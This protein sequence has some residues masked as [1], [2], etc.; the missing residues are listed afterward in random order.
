MNSMI[1]LLLVMLI[2]I[3]VMIA[4]MFIPYWT[5]RTESFGVSIP[6]EIYH[7]TELKEM[8]KK[9]AA[10]IGILSILVMLIFLICI[11]FIGDNENTI[12]LGLSIMVMLLIGGGFLVYLRFH[13]KMKSLKA[14][15]AWGKEKSSQVVLNTQF[16]NQKLTYSNLWFIL[17]F[18]I[19]LTMMMITLQLYDQIPDRIPMQYNFE[20]E[21]TNWTEKSY[22]SVLVMPIMQVYLTLLFLFINTMIAKAKQ[23]VSAE[24][25]EQSL[26]QNVVFRRRWSAFIIIT[27]TALTLLF[28]FIQLSFIYP[29]NNQL[30]TIVPIIFGIGVTI[31]SIVLS[32][33][34]G[35]GGS[36]IN[37]RSEG[38]GTA[39]NRDDDEHWKLGQ[40]YYNK[41]DPSLFL[42]KRFGIGWTV[43]F[44]RPAAWMIFILIILLAVGIPVILGA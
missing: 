22:R 21:V 16:H 11:S 6:Q 29:I 4:L 35:Q 31:G 39:L 5:R 19:S 17:P 33:S 14:A 13:N 18:A 28:S 23:Q 41:K 27:G 42:E 43:N 3:P 2:F 40:F 38:S 44:A 1:G 30:L 15:E 32:F 7:H 26:Q 36:R 25:P 24:N 10:L 8:R 9:Y 37:V 12:S 34:T 20:G